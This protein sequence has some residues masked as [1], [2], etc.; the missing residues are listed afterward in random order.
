MNEP[1]N[2]DPEQ[3]QGWLI[4]IA[5]L[6]FSLVN[7][8]RLATVDGEWGLRQWAVLAL[9]VGLLFLLWREYKRFKS[10]S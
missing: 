1:K 10:N 7:T 5:L 8:Y 6:L 3:K 4:P 9:T 2:N